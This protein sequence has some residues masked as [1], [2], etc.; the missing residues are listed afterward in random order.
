MQIQNLAENLGLDV[1]D[2]NELFEL[3]VE[4]TSSELKELKAAIDAG[5]A[6]KVHEKAHSLKGS[7]PVQR[8]LLIPLAGFLLLLIGGFGLVLFKTRQGSLNQFSKQILE[9]ASGELAG[10][11]NNGATEPE[12]VKELKTLV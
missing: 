9:D 6:E 12:L 5:D 8:R 7:S 11:L 1:E 10:S 2:F 4:T 3:Y